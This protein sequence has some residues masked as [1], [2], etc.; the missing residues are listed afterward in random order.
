MQVRESHSDFP[1]SSNDALQLT[2]L[3]RC[4]FIP[5]LIIVLSTV[6][7][8]SLPERWLSLCLVRRMS[9]PQDGSHIV[10]DGPERILDGSGRQAAVRIRARF[11][12]LTSGLFERAGLVGRFLIRYRTSRFVRR[13]LARL[14]PIEALYSS[15]QLSASPQGPIRSGL[16]HAATRNV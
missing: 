11:A 3:L 4:A 13:R 9:T 5:N 15:Q 14:A 6:A 1:L 10:A 12:R 8:P 7:Q 2:A 16:S